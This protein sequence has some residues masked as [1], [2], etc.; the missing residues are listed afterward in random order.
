M[1]GVPI[2]LNTLAAIYN[3]NEF[4]KPKYFSSPIKRFDRLVII[5]ETNIINLLFIFLLR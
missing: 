1:P 5:I 3:F 4:F 2:P